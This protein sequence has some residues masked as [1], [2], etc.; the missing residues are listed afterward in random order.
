[1]NQDD[2]LELLGR[3]FAYGELDALGNLLHEECKYNSDYAHRRL[4][5]ADQILKNMKAVHEAVQSKKDQDCSYSFEMVELKDV[6]QES[7]KP[8]DLHGDTFWDVYEKGLLLY[9]FGDP[10]PA[11]VVF[12]KFNPGGRFS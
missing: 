9:Q 2:K 4:T 10:A 6:L 3:A 7:V 1:M 8:D 5:S 11:A 12:V